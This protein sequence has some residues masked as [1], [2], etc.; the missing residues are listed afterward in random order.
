M[1]CFDASQ[2]AL[3][4]NEIINED[5]YIVVDDAEDPVLLSESSDRFIGITKLVGAAIRVL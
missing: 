3:V 1:R 2:T 4:A 5:L